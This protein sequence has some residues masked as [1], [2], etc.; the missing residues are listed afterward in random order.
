M[1]KPSLPSFA[2]KAAPIL[3]DRHLPSLSLR[4]VTTSYL[5]AISLLPFDVFVRLLL[6][7][8]AEMLEVTVVKVLHPMPGKA[9]SAAPR[10]NFPALAILCGLAGLKFAYQFTEDR[11]LCIHG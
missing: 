9:G 11:P 4:L 7:E 8:R 1:L 5:S 2:G 6:F 3:V 10:G